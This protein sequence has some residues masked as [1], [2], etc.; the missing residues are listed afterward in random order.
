MQ[1]MTRII[2]EPKQQKIPKARCSF[3]YFGHDLNLSKTNHKKSHDCKGLIW[4]TFK[5]IMTFCVKPLFHFVACLQFRLT[6]YSLSLQ[7]LFLMIELSQRLF[8]ALI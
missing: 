6:L 7:I 4:G 2:I 8:S 5:P 1:T 3:L